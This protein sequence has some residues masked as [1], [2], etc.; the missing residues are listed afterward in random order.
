M[1]PDIGLS[2]DLGNVI[3]ITDSSDALGLNMLANQAK[4]S[5]GPS[6]SSAPPTTVNVASSA[7]V[8]GGIEVSNLE[9]LEPITLNMDSAFGGMKEAPMEIK[10]TKEPAAPSFLPI[11]KP[12]QV[13]PSV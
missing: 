11:N 5:F 3:D 8:L 2:N 13:L 12:R 1:G 9:P 6:S 7:P 4:I 10:F